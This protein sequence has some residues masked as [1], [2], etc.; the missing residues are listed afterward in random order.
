MLWRVSKYGLKFRS[1]VPARSFVRPSAVCA[2]DVL[3]ILPYKPGKLLFGDGNGVRFQPD[4]FGTVFFHIFQIHQISAV[5]AVK[6][7]PGL[8]GELFQL[9]VVFDIAVYRVQ[10][11]LAVEDF[12]VNNVRE[13]NL[14]GETTSFYENRAWSSQII[15][16]ACVR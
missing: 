14:C 16:A 10:Q 6:I 4:R 11:N 2:A 13:Q 1:I 8:I 3:H 7:S 9:S 15:F 12:R 5:R